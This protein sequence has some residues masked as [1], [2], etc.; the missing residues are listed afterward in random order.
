MG[1]FFAELN[2]DTFQVPAQEGL[3][4]WFEQ[5]HAEHQGRQ[6]MVYLVAEVGGV[7]AGSI[8]ASLLEPLDTAARQVQSDFSR[9]RLHIDVL[10]VFAAHRRSGVGTALMRAAEQWGRARGAEVI[11]LETETNNPLSMSFYEQRMGMSPGVVVF[12]KEMDPQG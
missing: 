11:L 8:G 1:G 5:G 4:E 10:G 12:R 2:P 3:A 9:R 7:L 6:D